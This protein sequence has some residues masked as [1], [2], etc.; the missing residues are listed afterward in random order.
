MSVLGGG[1]PSKMVPQKEANE[2]PG[3]NVHQK[4]NTIVPA[5][6]ESS[7]SLTPRSLLTPLKVQERDIQV[8]FIENVFR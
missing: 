6:G 5:N 8:Q 1:V 4:H 7:S 3:R 2:K